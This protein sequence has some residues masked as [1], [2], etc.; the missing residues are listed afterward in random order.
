MKMRN[1][2]PSL[3][4]LSKPALVHAYIYA[5]GL[6]TRTGSCV[7]ILTFCRCMIT[8]RGKNRGGVQGVPLFWPK[9]R[10]IYF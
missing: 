8:Q 7:R 3:Y 5:I 9:F 10:Y 2:V 6:F 4:Y 1:F